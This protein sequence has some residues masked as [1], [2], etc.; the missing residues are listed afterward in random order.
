MDPRQGNQNFTAGGQSNG[1]P[2]Y[3]YNGAQNDP[4]SSFI[5]TEDEGAFDNTW[6]TPDYSSHQQPSNAFDQSSQ[7][8]HQ[9]PYQT[10]GSN[11]LPMPQYNIDS[12]YAAGESGFQFSSF[13]SNPVQ[14]FASRESLPPSTYTNESSYDHGPLSND[15]H[16]QYSGPQEL[17]E[18]SATISP[19]AIESYP[20]YPPASFGEGSQVCQI[21]FVS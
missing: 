21:Q 7:S 17:E 12:R 5:N 6:Q 18:A 11:F 2:N 8:W 1:G 10:P 4:F 9:S 3:P 20:N 15:T 16:F 13:N 19:R 14:E